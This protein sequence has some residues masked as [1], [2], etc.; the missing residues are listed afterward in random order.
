M[1]Y[2]IRTLLLIPILFLSNGYTQ[3]WTTWRLP[4]DAERRIGKGDISYLKFSPD[5]SRLAVS[6]TIGIWMYDT[7]T[8][9]ELALFTGHTDRVEALVFS[10]DGKILASGGM[11]NSM[12]LWNWEKVVESMDR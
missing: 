5:G 8:G 4:E 3:D 2:L 6:T 1:R 10:P 12:L 7:H 9:A 11:D